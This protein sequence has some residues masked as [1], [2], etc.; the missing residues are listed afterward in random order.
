MVG[1]G[2]MMRLLPHQIVTNKSDSDKFGHISPLSELFPRAVPATPPFCMYVFYRTGIWNES[3]YMYMY[4]YI[5]VE[6]ASD[7]ITDCKL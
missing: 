5:H 7:N 6:Q 3:T 4:M 2:V 1:D